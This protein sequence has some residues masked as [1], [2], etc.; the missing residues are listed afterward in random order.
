MFFCLFGFFV[1]SPEQ[2]KIVIYDSKVGIRIKA[3]RILLS[4]QTIQEE[5]PPELNLRNSWHTFAFIYLLL[6]CS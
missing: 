1:F 4:L 5:G 3:T 2:M 6:R